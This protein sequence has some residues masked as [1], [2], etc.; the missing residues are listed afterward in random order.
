MALN[1]YLWAVNSKS[2]QHSTFISD[3]D[4]D[5]VALE[6]QETVTCDPYR[7]TVACK[8]VLLEYGILW[9]IEVLMLLIYTYLLTVSSTVLPWFGYMLVMWRY[10]CDTI[11]IEEW[12][13]HERA[14][15]CSIVRNKRGT[16][17]YSDIA[18]F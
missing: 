6:Q 14:L 18:W 11:K 15:T 16:Y 5:W 13:K 10:V 9:L 3:E 4:I 12:P 2:S 8:N 1:G 17:I 7:V